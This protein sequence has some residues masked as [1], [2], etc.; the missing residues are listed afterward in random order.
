MARNKCQLESTTEKVSRVLSERYGIRVIFQGSECKTDGR[1]IYLPSLPEDLPDE[2]ADAIRGWADHEVS[3]VLF[4]ESE[5]ASEF[6]R[7]HGPRAFGILNTLEDARVERLMAE[8]YP[9]SG[10]NIDR[11]VRYVEKLF[12]QKG[13]ALINDPLRAF[14]AALYTRAS[15]RKDAAYVPD[16]FYAMADMCSDEL[17]RLH[18]CKNTSEVAGLTESILDKITAAKEQE[19]DNQAGPEESDEEMSSQQGPQGQ[20]QEPGSQPDS[21]PEDDAGSQDDSAEDESTENQDSPADSEECDE[22]EVDSQQGQ[23]NRSESEQPV[24]DP[25][26]ESGISQDAQSEVQEES[27]DVDSQSQQENTGNADEARDAVDDDET[28]RDRASQMAA[29]LEEDGEEEGDGEFS[30]LDQIKSHLEQQFKLSDEVSESYRPYT[31]E[32]DVVEVPPDAPSYK[33]QDEM[34][35]IRP[36]VSGLMRR[37]V[38]TLKGRHEKRWLGE[39]ARG[40]LDPKALHKLA[41]GTGSRI[42]RTRTETDDGKTA[43]TL[44][45]DISSSMGGERINMCKK[46]ALVFGETLSRL[47][48]PTEIIGFSTSDR[49]LRYEVSRETGIEESTLSKTYS[50]MVPLYH[51]IYKQFNEPWIRGAARIGEIRKKCLTPLGESLLFAGKRLAARPEK[52][53]VL[54]CLTDGEPV[55]GAW[56]ESVTMEHARGAVKKLTAAGIEPIGLGIMAPYVKDI[57]PRH[58]CIYS[59]RQLPTTFSKQ[60]CDVLTERAR[61]QAV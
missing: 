44:L 29:A 42:F 11:A 9:G 1:V 35:F 40:K 53:K 31:L 24:D 51:G 4:S 45:L 6:S 26:S 57:F 55:T 13:N 38:H 12:T 23:D 14:G 3:H 52:R 36:Q 56:D 22:E 58:A 10:I 28:D 39:K 25:S 2:M 59:L 34:R 18:G 15:G 50:R 7:K 33:W 37:L 43:C 41:G 21:Q 60:L 47:S 30:P 20:D 49:D 48:F 5:T 8:R 32:H 54:F 61:Q 17:S 19:E 46:L 27:S 16:E